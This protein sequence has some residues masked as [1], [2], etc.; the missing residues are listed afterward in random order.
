MGGPACARLWSPPLQRPGG[1]LSPRP[2]ALQAPSQ[3]CM[4]GKRPSCSPLLTDTFPPLTPCPVGL[5]S[6]DSTRGVSGTW[7]SVPLACPAAPTAPRPVPPCGSST[8]TPHCRK[9]ARARRPWFRGRKEVLE[10][11]ATALHG[12]R[13]SCTLQPPQHPATSLTPCNLRSHPRTWKP[14]GSA[15]ARRGPHLHGVRGP[16]RGALR[17]GTVSVVKALVRA[18]R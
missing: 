3:A 6:R 5:C 7:H 10:R 4:A 13:A 9:R 15:S 14:R 8:G 17:L 18:E 16:P 12:G 11:S 1:P 2:P